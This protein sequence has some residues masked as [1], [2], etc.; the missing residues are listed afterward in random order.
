MNARSAGPF[1]AARFALHFG[2]AAGKAGQNQEIVLPD[3]RIA[4]ILVTR[5]AAAVELRGVAGP[6]YMGGP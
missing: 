3:Q 2:L 4:A 1:H 6:P 5:A